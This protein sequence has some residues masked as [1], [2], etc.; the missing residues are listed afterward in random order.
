M[1]DYYLYLDPDDGILYVQK[2]G[3]VIAPVRTSASF[4]PKTIRIK[5]GYLQ[6]RDFDTNNWKFICDENGQPV[7]LKGPA[8]DQAVLDLIK[9]SFSVLIGQDQETDGNQQFTTYL[10]YYLNSN[11][12][13]IDCEENIQVE[14]SDKITVYLHNETP[15]KV[16]ITIVIPASTPIKD[17]EGGIKLKTVGLPFACASIHLLPDYLPKE[18]WKIEECNPSVIKV[19]DGSIDYTQLRVILTPG[20]TVLPDGYQL[21]AIQNSKE[22]MCT[23]GPQLKE[24]IFNI[25]G[26]NTSDDIVITLFDKD[27][28]DVSKRIVQF[29]HEQKNWNEEIDNKIEQ[30]QNS[31]DGK[32]NSTDIKL[33]TNNKTIYGA[34]NEIYKNQPQKIHVSNISN[35]LSEDL[36]LTTGVYFVILPFI[37]DIPEIDTPE[38]ASMSDIPS[39]NIYGRYGL[40][41]V[42][43]NQTDRTMTLILDDGVYINKEYAES[44]T[45]I[46]WESITSTNTTSN[47]AD[48]LNNLETQFADQQAKLASVDIEGVASVWPAQQTIEQ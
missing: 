32:Q 13:I 12:E 30:L 5:D 28:E 46:K 45:E 38:V 20:N 19:Q 24:Y 10:N 7:S 9:D 40:L 3:E 23:Q 48:R 21:K 11:Q 36:Q 25:D 22:L 14:C 6:I 37:P 4:D 15:Y 29:L 1:K 44:W 8:G 39:L 43:T 18:E 17:V 35:L 31:I 16:K 2:D 26:N 34:I 47:L 42:S 41:L 27:G 33:N